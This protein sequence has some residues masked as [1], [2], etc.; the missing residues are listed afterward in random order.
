MHKLS[1]RTN[2]TFRKEGERHSPAARISYSDAPEPQTTTF[3]HLTR[4]IQKPK[5]PLSCKSRACPLLRSCVR[6]AIA[7]GT[8]NSSRIFLRF[9]RTAAGVTPLNN[10]V[11]SGKFPISGARWCTGQKAFG[12]TSK[13]CLHHATGN[14]SQPCYVLCC[15][16]ILF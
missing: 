16:N 5:I 12:H 4:A 7:F 9:A 3:A 1:I 10:N 11:P 6:Y 13:A 8:F 2:H 15:T 14:T